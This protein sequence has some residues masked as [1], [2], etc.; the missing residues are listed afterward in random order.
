MALLWTLQWSTKKRWLTC[1]MVNQKPS[2][3]LLSILH[4]ALHPQVLICHPPSIKAPLATGQTDFPGLLWE[5]NSCLCNLRFLMLF[6]WAG[7]SA[8]SEI[9]V[10]AH[11]VLATPART[12][13]SW[14]A[15]GSQTQRSPRCRQQDVRAGWREA[16][17]CFILSHSLVV[18]G[19]ML[20]FS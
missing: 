12:T 11:H 4:P 8:G 3:C 19:W 20:L 13:A 18:R 9:A 5:H 7:S 6:P 15:R 2:L 14:G 1:K 17:W 16:G 10:L